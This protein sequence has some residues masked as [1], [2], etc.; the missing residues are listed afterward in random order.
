M[1]FQQ[2]A[3]YLAASNATAGL[4]RTA[5]RVLLCAAVISGLVT[6]LSINSVWGTLV[7]CLSAFWSVFS[8][9]VAVAS[10]F[11]GHGLDSAGRT[12]GRNAWLL[13]IAAA[14]AQYTAQTFFYVRTNMVSQL[15]EHYATTPAEPARVAQAQAW[16]ARNGLGLRWAF[17]GC[18]MLIACAIVAVGYCNEGPP[19]VALLVLV[20]MGAFCGFFRSLEPNQPFCLRSQAVRLARLKGA[21]LDKVVKDRNK[22]FLSEAGLTWA[23]AMTAVGLLDLTQPEGEAAFAQALAQCS[24]EEALGAQA[25]ARDLAVAL[26]T[27]EF[28]RDES[29]V[30]A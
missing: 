26:R 5:S 10:G 27:G 24:D 11:V 2:S 3:E 25:I 20:L 13:F 28:P 29:V 12:L 1:K 7:E 30:Q 15:A 17:Y 4:R 23:R 21:Q 22:W 18:W 9:F 16:A 19:L 6:L 14:V 8:R